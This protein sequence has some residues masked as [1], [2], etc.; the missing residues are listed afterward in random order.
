MPH[1]SKLEDNEYKVIFSDYEHGCNAYRTYNPI[2]KC[3]RVT[4]DVVFNEK[5]Q[6]D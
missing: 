5:A 2:K 4:R 3:V 1:L 6:W